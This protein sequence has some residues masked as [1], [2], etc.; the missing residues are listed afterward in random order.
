MPRTQ[1]AAT[2]AQGATTNPGGGWK[3]GG[4]A[5][6]A[7]TWTTEP[8]GDDTMRAYVHTTLELTPD[9]QRVSHIEKRL[10]QT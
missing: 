8:Q 4:R 1:L 7:I 6:L 5:N 9:A 2:D 3:Q 10:K